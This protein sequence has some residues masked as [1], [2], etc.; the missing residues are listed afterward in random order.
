MDAHDA[1]PDL[2]AALDQASS[3]LRDLAP[4]MKTYFDALHEAG[5]TPYQA[6]QMTMSYQA[7]L[8]CKPEPT[9]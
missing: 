1:L 2:G 6:L 3:A 7:A 5:F 8:I 9:S 4:M